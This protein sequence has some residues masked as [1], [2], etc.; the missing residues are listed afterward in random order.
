MCVFV[1]GC[2]IFLLVSMSWVMVRL[3]CLYSL[4][5]LLLLENG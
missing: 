2:Y 3:C 1:L 4:S 5:S